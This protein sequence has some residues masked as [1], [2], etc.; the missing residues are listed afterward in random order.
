MPLKFDEALRAQYLEHLR[1]GNLKFESARLCGIAY[2]TVERRRKNDPDFVEQEQWAMA[3]AR[4]GVE[5]VLHSAALQGD[6]AAIRMWLSAHDK[7]TYADKKTVEIDATP[8]AVEL[9]KA[10]ALTAIADLQRTLAERSAQ[11]QSDDVIEVQLSAPKLA[12]P[13]EDATSVAPD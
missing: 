4:E 6:M 10:E 11:L 5:K 7:S 8:A 12:S 3:E 1:A 9:G 2:S 13:D